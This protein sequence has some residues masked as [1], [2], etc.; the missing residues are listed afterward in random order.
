MVVNNATYAF[1]DQ[2]GKDEIEHPLPR[3]SSDETVVPH[4]CHGIKETTEYCVIT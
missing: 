2:K 4:T 1:C 3:L